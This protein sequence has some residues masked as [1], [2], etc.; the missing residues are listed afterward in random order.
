M[1]NVNYAA[2]TGE[3]KGFYPDDIGYPSIPEP[4]IEIDAATHQGCINN[5]GRRRVDLNTLQIVE[6]NP[7]PT[8]SE[9][10]AAKL[11]E[12][13]SARNAAE[14]AT[15]FV[16]DG[17]SFDYDA[18][19]RERI[20]AAVSG[21]TIAVVSGTATSTVVDEWTLAD[22][23]KRNM[24]IADWL[25]FRQAEITRRGTYRT[26]YN[27]LKA[28]VE[29]LVTE[30]SVGTKTES[31]AIVAINA[32]SCIFDTGSPT[33][34]TAEVKLAQKQKLTSEYAGYRD[35]YR[36]AWF[37]ATANKDSVTANE[38]LDETAAL[39]VELMRKKEAIDNE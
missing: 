1:I 38:I 36:K 2:I 6:Y 21:A 11:A 34:T 12:L 39:E 10:Q 9:T 24:T 30:V 22:N 16:Y 3:I 23:S 26:T 33:K 18:L 37:G 29:A 8:L 5:P 17:S 31:E 20:N 32:I 14:S 7:V 35:N 25:A 13:K 27:T 15:P 19:S 4:T 28:Q